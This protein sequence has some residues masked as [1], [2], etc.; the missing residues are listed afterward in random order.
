M[1]SLKQFSKLYISGEYDFIKFVKK[2]FKNSIID[3]LKSQSFAEI[4]PTKK[5]NVHS[6]GH[7]QSKSGNA[8]KRRARISS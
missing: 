3:I 4:L 6:E 2:A 8:K 7:Y 1:V 5:D